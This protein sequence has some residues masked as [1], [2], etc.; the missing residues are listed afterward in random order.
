MNEFVN[1]QIHNRKKLISRCLRQCS[2]SFSLC[3]IRSRTCSVHF[4]EA[5]SHHLHLEQGFDVQSHL[6]SEAALSNSCTVFNEKTCTI[7]RFLLPLF[8]ATDF[9]SM[10]QR[11][12]VP[13]VGGPSQKKFI[14]FIMCRNYSSSS[15]HPCHGPLR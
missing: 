13:V 8:T 14:F 7:S 15:H 11:G 5:R 12:G 10:T 4:V 3:I 1:L 6:L 9:Q 2:H